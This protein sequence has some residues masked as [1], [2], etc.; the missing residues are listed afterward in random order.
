MAAMN[1]SLAWT[2][3]IL[4]RDRSDPWSLRPTMWL[5]PTTQSERTPAST[6]PRVAGVFFLGSV[7]QIFGVDEQV[8]DGVLSDQGVFGPRM[9]ER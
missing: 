1:R 9:W 6:Y 8:P 5:V 2:D 3:K 7:E 4:G